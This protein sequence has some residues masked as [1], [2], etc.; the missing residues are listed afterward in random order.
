MTVLPLSARLIVQGGASF[1]Y[2]G[3]LCQPQNHELVL[4]PRT[5]GVIHAAGSLFAISV[6]YA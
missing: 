4:P 6:Y 5:S 3:Q 2:R 1:F